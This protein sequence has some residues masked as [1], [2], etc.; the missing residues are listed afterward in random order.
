ME[1]RNLKK[2]R[3]AHFGIAHDHSAVTMECAR[4]YPDI[5]E[6]VG[7][8]EPDEETRNT[9]GNHPAY[10]G[11]PWLTE[12][13]LLS[14]DDIDAVL[15]EGHE[16]RS[17]SDAQKCIDRGFHVHLD[18]PGG[19]DIAAFEALLKSAHQKG[20]TLQMGY[21]YRYN[22]AFRRVMEAVREGTLGTITG[23][24]GTFS[25][26]HPSEK[27]KWLGQ[28]PGGM[29]FYIGCHVIDMILLLNG[30]PDDVHPFNRSSDHDND[31]SLDSA[32]AV[33]DYP[34][35]ACTVRTNAT[36]INGYARRSLLV[37]GT[38]ASIEIRPLE[39]PTL[40]NITTLEDAKKGPGSDDASRSV[41]PGYLPGRYDDMMLEFSACVRGEIKNPYSWEYE[42]ELQKVVLAACGL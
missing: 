11:I 2:I 32:F 10:A 24:D 39:C 19:T 28:F 4:K 23:I 7:I 13:E 15:C 40:M 1:D 27:R 8:C 35:G 33:L 12:D 38:K 42:L 37:S 30:L 25:I 17:V 21:M 34:R 29:M 22:P 3:T 6:I 14:R 31:G 36:E 20:L 18:K 26:L 41:F 9:M 5:F 16:L